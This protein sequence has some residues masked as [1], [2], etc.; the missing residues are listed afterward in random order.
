M[1]GFNKIQQDLK[2]FED[3]TGF[4]RLRQD[5][6]GNALQQQQ[7]QQQQKQN[8]EG[9]ASQKLRSLKKRRWL[10]QK[11]VLYVQRLGESFSNVIDLISKEE[12]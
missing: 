3:L 1:K 6:L 12:K 7:Q 11:Y 5:Y 2:G 4:D 9:C 10:N 8:I